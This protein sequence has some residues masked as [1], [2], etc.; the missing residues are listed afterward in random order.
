MAGY[1]VAPTLIVAHGI[2]CVGWCDYMVCVLG[3]IHIMYRRLFMIERNLA[4]RQK[5]MSGIRRELM[6]NKRD[7][8]VT[9]QGF[10]HV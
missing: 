9:G 8:K 5:E 1:P 4:E 6:T 2:L 3:Y 7:I 10:E